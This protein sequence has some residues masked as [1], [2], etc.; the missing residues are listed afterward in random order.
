MTSR[1]QWPNV[2][3]LGH[4][5][6]S[7]HVGPVPSGAYLPEKGEPGFEFSR[8]LLHGFDHPCEVRKLHGERGGDYRLPSLRAK[9]ASARPMGR[10]G[11]SGSG[12]ATSPAACDASPRGCALPCLESVLRTCILESLSQHR[13]KQPAPSSWRHPG[14]IP[15]VLRFGANP[16]SHCSQGRRLLV[17]SDPDRRKR[18]TRLFLSSTGRSTRRPERFGP[19]HR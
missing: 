18:S 4:M 14:P 8:S 2:P 15:S 17:R 13:A 9:H 3:E 11:I 19:S 5:L 1:A 16:A 12:G 6:D 10:S 7:A